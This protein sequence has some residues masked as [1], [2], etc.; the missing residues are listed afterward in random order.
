[1]YLTGV[2]G[3]NQPPNV[4]PAEMMR[5][6]MMIP[7]TKKPDRLG[8]IGGDLAGYPNGRRPIDDTVDISLRAVAGVLIKEFQVSPNKDLGDGVDKADQPYLDAFPFLGDPSPGR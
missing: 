5:L 2:P 8:V 4:R 6:N 7:P 1:M 3:L